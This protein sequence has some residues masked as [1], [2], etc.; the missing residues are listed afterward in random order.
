[1]SGTEPST[2]P[3]GIVPHPGHHQLRDVSITPSDRPAGPLF[4]DP[5][6]NSA[7]RRRAG[8]TRLQRIRQRHPSADPPSRPA[9]APEQVNWLT[10]LD[11][12]GTLLA[13]L[14]TLAVAGFTYISV[15]QA[16]TALN[17]TAQG[18]NADRY[19]SAVQ[20]LGNRSPDIRAGSVYALQ[21]IMHDSPQYQ[22]TIISI[23]SSFVRYHAPL[24]VKVPVGA[25][26]GTFDVVAALD[27]LGA[28]DPDHD[29][30]A[31]VDLHG[32]IL[33]GAALGNA[34]LVGADLGHAHLNG[35]DLRG[36]DLDGA[37]L[38]GADLGGANLGAARVAKT[39]WTTD[40]KWPSEL[41][42]PYMRDLSTP[43]AERTFAI[44]PAVV[45]PASGSAPR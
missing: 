36:A 41:G 18:Q 40:T 32:A 3:A 20:T 1:M 23:L 22:P 43:N 21:Q 11:K 7:P 6:E 14:A 10:A 25:S 39:R 8:S 42:F 12:V 30:A 44:R 38:E 9:P 13:S 15:H 5:M 26:R 34:N 2:V 35:A 33:V 17:I 28:R 29:G 45:L 16:S 19:E 27:V 31:H 37:S 4:S 24:S